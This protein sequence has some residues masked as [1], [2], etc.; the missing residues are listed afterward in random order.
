MSNTVAN[1]F[2]KEEFLKEPRTKLDILNLL[3]YAEGK[4]RVVI[5]QEKEELADML[6]RYHYGNY[7][8]GNYL[9]DGIIEAW[10]VWKKYIPEKFFSYFVVES[11]KSLIKKHVTGASS[12]PCLD[13]YIGT[14]LGIELPE[15]PEKLFI[16]VNMEG[17]C[18]VNGK[19]IN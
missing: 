12:L 3:Y 9:V 18:L 2:K 7:N 1:N 4:H 5:P 10:N 16:T 17:V 6:Y 15:I 8:I 14:R 13:S 11:L 19:R